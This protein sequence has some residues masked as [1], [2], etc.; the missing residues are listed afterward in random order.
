VTKFGLFIT[1]NE[2]GADGLIPA[3]DLG[4]EYFV[5]D[6]R[7]RALIGVDTGNT[8]RFG[9]KVKTRLKEATPVTGGLVFEMLSKPDKGAKPKKRVADRNRKPGRRG[10][11]GGQRR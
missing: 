10:R 6:E 7:K 11:K 3:R 2:T 4:H 8:Y 9:K 1:L 5:F